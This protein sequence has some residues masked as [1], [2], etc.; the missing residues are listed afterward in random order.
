M[1]RSQLTRIAALFA[2]ACAL[3]LAAEPA[4]ASC[5]CSTLPTLGAALDYPA[6]SLF[7]EVSIS[8]TVWAENGNVGLGNKLGLNGKVTASGSS[9][10]LA[11][12]F[13]APGTTVTISGGATVGSVVQQDMSSVPSPA[14]RPIPRSRAT[15]AST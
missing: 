4:R 1:D 2:L 8:G 14:S 7:K 10:V 5:N 3:G 9:T 15:A 11:K 6:M 12:I 13:N